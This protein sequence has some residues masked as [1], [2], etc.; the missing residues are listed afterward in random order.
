MAIQPVEKRGRKK[1]F[2]NGATPLQQLIALDL[3]MGEGPYNVARKRKV[4]YEAVNQWLKHPFFKDLIEKHKQKYIDKIEEAKVLDEIGTFKNI[5][6][7]GLA[8]NKLPDWA[9]VIRAL[10]NLSKIKDLYSPEKIEIKQKEELKGLSSE[11][12]AQL[13]KE[14]GITNTDIFTSQGSPKK[15][16]GGGETEVQ[17][18]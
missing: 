4:S 14:R 5:V 17:G 3:A 11:K 6:V 8:S 10:E 7:R 2:E 1:L 12:L 9:S 15:N 16:T 13:L 18:G